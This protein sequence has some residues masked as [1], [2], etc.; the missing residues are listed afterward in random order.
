MS[1]LTKSTKSTK[2]VRKSAAAAV[3]TAAVETVT[4]AV[5]SAVIVPPKP[6]KL[7]QN[8]NEL[9]AALCRYVLDTDKTAETED[10]QCRTIRALAAPFTKTNK[11]GV[12]FVNPCRRAGDQ[13]YSVSELRG[14]CKGLGYAARFLPGG[15]YAK[16][17]GYEPR[18]A[19]LIGQI[20]AAH[21][22]GEDT[23]ASDVPEFA[24][25]QILASE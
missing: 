24:A 14:I 23:F 13:G 19:E 3:E 18:R 21:G 20:V 1:K 11:F 4:P 25:A 8:A 7:A 22:T 2:S 17:H 15:M 5:V 9:G 16:T 12:E 10:Q 6:I